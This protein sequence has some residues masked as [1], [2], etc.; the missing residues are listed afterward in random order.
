[1][2]AELKRITEQERRIV[3]DRLDRSRAWELGDFLRRRAVERELPVVVGVTIGRQR[4]FHAALAGATPD[5]DA[6]LDRKIAAV[7]HFERSS[8]GVR[9]QFAAQ[10]RD[11]AS[12]SRLD[13]REIAANGGAFP[14]TVRGLGVVGAAGISGL[15][16][17]D[18]HEF[19][20]DGLEAFLR[21]R[22]GSH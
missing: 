17:M 20:V 12:D 4:V 6:W 5:N 3:F 2:S 22:R 1:M 7:M 19:V 11:Y 15:A 9:G 13:H 8:A 14:L 16:Q 10:G 18:D 21:E